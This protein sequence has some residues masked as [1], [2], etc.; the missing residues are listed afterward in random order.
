VLGVSI[1]DVKP[2][3]A[4]AAGLS[5]IAGA[6]I[7]SFEPEN[8]SPA[9][10]AG[11][12]IGDVIVAAGGHQ[13]DQVSTLQ[14]IIRGYQ[15]GE[16]VDLDVMRFGSKKTLHVKLGEPSAD[17][18]TVASNDETPTPTRKSGETNS[19][20]N[21]KLG[22][23]VAPV[24]N[25]FAQQTKLAGT[26]RSGLLVTNVAPTGPSFHDLVPNDII[27]Q[28]LSPAKRAIH[29]ADDLQ[30]AVSSVARGEVISLMVCYPNP[31]AGTCQ[32]RVV[33]IRIGQ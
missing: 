29:S 12:E 2:N 21:D 3:T 26:A 14:R 15:P 28:E 22:V 33:A 30:A 23:S 24:S 7:E 32:T 16:V 20:Q 27:L 11:A 9:K 13:V 31:S 8:D 18:A 4:R 17:N 6:E 25:E 19:R 5:T 10:R 1:Q